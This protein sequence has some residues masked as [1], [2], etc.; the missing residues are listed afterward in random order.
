MAGKYVQTAASRWRVSVGVRQRRSPF[1]Y[2]GGLA[3]ER[4]GDNSD[5]AS[6]LIK[7]SRA[8]RRLIMNMK[9]CALCGAVTEKAAQIRGG[10]IVCAICFETIMSIGKMAV[11]KTLDAAIDALH[12]ACS[13]DTKPLTRAAGEPVAE[14]DRAFKTP[15]ARGNTCPKCSGWLFEYYDRN[16]EV[17]GL[18]CTICDFIKQYDS[19]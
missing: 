9:N 10:H 4:R 13:S 7:I 8:R 3:A 14:P 11:L 2:S 1:G 15:I 16:G 12:R 19:E 17:A 6:L 18:A 5:I